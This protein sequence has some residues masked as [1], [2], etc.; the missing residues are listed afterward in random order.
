MSS[1]YTEDAEIWLQAFKILTLH[2]F[3]QLH[4]PVTLLNR[5]PLVHIG[6]EAGRAL[7]LNMVGK[8][9]I[10]LLEIKQQLHSPLSFTPTEVFWFIKHYRSPV[11]TVLFVHAHVHFK[12]VSI[13][14]YK[15]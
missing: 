10:S 7:Q 13:K 14:G 5:E 6:Y 2:G 12:H 3:H 1:V 8:R 4:D 9:Q 11:L 15:Q